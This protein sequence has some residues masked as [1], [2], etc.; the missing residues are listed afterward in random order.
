MPERRVLQLRCLTASRTA[1]P[2]RAK[3]PAGH[4][5]VLERVI[6]VDEVGERL[7]LTVARR[8]AAERGAQPA[9][10]VNDLFSCFAVRPTIAIT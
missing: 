2:P 7:A 9:A 3:R 5:N 10:R 4:A 6:V 1:L 8:P